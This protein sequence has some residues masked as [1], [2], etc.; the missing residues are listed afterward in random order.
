VKIPLAIIAVV[1]DVLANR[2]SH[3][4]IDYFVGAAGLEGEQP[5]ANKLDKVRFWL[6]RANSDEDPEPLAIL[7]KVINEMMESNV[8]VQRLGQEFQVSLE[9]DRDRI[10]KALG[11]YGLTYVKGGRVVRTGV[12]AV[13]ETIEDL[14]EAHDLSGLQAEYDRIA[15][16]VETDPAAAVT[17][18]CA[19]LES[20][21]KVY[22]SEEK[23]E[24]PSDKSLGPLWKVVRGH[25]KLEPDKMQEDDVR[26]VLVG[27]GAIVDGIAALRT[28]KGSAHGHESHTYK[29][30]PRHARLASHAAFT[31][32]TFIIETWEER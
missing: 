24:M 6:T 13:S 11:E 32:A 17:A 23:L 21:F 10:Q 1:S 18:S 19:L 15:S 14:I 25:L 4:R 26:K 8:D 28:H 7:G 9:A 16:N 3:S 29:V 12:R 30:K 22:I 20:L 2:Y 31:L 27:L 5:S